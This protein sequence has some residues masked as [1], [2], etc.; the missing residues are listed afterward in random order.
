ME[1]NEGELIYCPITGLGS[2][3]L[4]HEA[5]HWRKKGAFI[6][7][8]KHGKRKRPRI[9]SNE[10]TP[11]THREG[12]QAPNETVDPTLLDITEQPSALSQPET[13]LKFLNLT[14][15][16]PTTQNVTVL[17][18]FTTAI[19]FRLSLITGDILD[20]INHS[21]DLKSE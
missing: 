17:K 2:H 18:P 5:L 4:N 12:S 3:I 8:K 10:S 19:V 9:D 20:W 14:V 21:E 6:F 11:E 7:E 13:P 1:Y 15:G 16:G